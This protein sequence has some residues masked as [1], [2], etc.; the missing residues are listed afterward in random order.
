MDDNVSTTV[1]YCLYTI[2]DLFD[3]RLCIIIPFLLQVRGFEKLI[4][5]YAVINSRFSQFS[6]EWNL[7]VPSGPCRIKSYEEFS[8]GL[9]Y[10][11][12]EKTCLENRQV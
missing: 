6:I 8:G 2:C 4:W 7:V 5:I 9:T 12:S 11:H 1:F 10:L 3:L